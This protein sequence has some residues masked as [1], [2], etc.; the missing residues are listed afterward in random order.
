MRAC[1]RGEKNEN[2]SELIHVFAA[3][4]MDILLRR[5]AAAF[6]DSALSVSKK[7]VFGGFYRISHTILAGDCGSD[8]VHSACCAKQGK[9]AARKTDPKIEPFDSGKEIF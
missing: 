8:C 3:M 9:T 6:G 7:G 1:L 4:E 2:Q 5:R